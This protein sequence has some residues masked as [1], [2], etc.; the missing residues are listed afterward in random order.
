MEWIDGKD[1]K[2]YINENGPIDIDTFINIS[3]QI[4]SALYYSHTKNILHRDLAERNI[5]ITAD[6]KVKI[7]D[8]GLAKNIKN[9]INLT[10]YSTAINTDNMA[11][12]LK[13]DIIK[14]INFNKFT[15]SIPIASLF[16]YFGYKNI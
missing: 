8:F 14:V 4:I 5:L 11:P 16:Q 6:E 2:D 3:K 7:L 13:E 1:L 9:G 10:T 15:T 12:Q